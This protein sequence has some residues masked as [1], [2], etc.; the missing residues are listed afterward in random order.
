MTQ[1][2]EQKTAWDRCTCLKV[3]HVGKTGSVK[4]VENEVEPTP[5]VYRVDPE[6]P[7]RWKPDHPKPSTQES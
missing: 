6:C 4:N 2:T 1:L 7:E 3:Y 5:V